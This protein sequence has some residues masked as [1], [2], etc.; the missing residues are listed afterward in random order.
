MRNGFTLLELMATVIIVGILAAVAMPQYTRA[1]NKARLAEAVSHLGSLQKGI[2]MYR[3][4]HRNAEA[5][6]LIP[7]GTRLDIDFMGQLDCDASAC[8]AKYFTYTAKCEADGGECIINVTP[9]ENEAWE[10]PTLTA[11]RKRNESGVG[12]TWKRLCSGDV[13][14]CES[15]QSAGFEVEEAESL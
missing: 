9:R 11:T 2:D 7:E 4:Q 3:L 5:T 13:N 8:S 10:L 12:A 14:L 15:L 1:V 6:F